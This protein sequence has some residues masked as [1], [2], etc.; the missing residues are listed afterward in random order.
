MASELDD[1]SAK[2]KELARVAGDRPEGEKARRLAERLTAGR[3]HI[4]V[5]GEFKRGKSTIVNALIGE[6]VVP[7]GV[8]PVTAVSTE[9]VF[10]GPGATVEYLDGRT[11][12]IAR[13]KITAFVTEAG[14]PANKLGVARVVV[15]G[16]WSLARPGIVL[17]DTPGLASLY[18][19]NTKAGRAA[20]L[21]A[22]GV[23]VV[24]SAD[25]PLSSEERDL[26]HILRERRAVTF[27]VLNKSD[28]LH[29][30]ELD[31]VRRF[32]E[33]A[34]G[35]ILG[36]KV[37]LFA[38]NARGAFCAQEIGGQGDRAGGEFPEFVA[39]LSRFISEDLQEA[40]ATSAK[41]ELARLGASLSEAVA[42]ERAA[43]RLAADD[44]SRLVLRFEDEATRQRRGFDD[45]QTLLA[46]DTGVLV[47]RVGRR[48]ADFSSM[49]AAR[50]LASLIET[51][52]HAP[53]SRLADELRAAIRSIVESEFDDFHPQAITQL[54]AEWQEV[55]TAFRS[56]VQARVDAARQSAADL[57]EVPLPWLPLPE[58]AAQRDR[59][60]FLFVHV[61]STTEVFSHG[62]PRLLPGRWARRAALR[63]AR[64]ELRREFDKHAGRARWD[65]AQRLEAA[66]FQLEKAMQS[67][68]ESSI[69]AI[70]Q[71]ADR[72]RR[73]H[74]QT[75]H[76]REEGD[77]RAARLAQLGADLVGFGAGGR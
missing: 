14:N 57:F 72:A 63:R 3:F 13:G 7:T 42:I 56:R 1:L 44:L 58:I 45:D 20:L 35:D 55:G 8:L 61:G 37:H 43:R 36:T 66:R 49:A 5:V 19:H 64:D 32:V 52:G 29:A 12:A 9:L 65:L 6:S 15:R 21:D 75:R 33:A 69:E 68:L 38:V 16:E 30:H 31:E 4:A 48:V 62:I 76:E 50:H 40:R 41:N 60:S 47:E 11:E 25:A 39:E 24:L 71:A 22:D 67:E 10:G 34:I 74:E 59:F 2:A 28:H 18:E 23:V 70:I 26:L 27:F 51:A 46:R 53:R 73:W 77:V 17:V 54:E